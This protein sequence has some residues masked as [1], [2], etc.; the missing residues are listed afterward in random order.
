MEEHGIKNVEIIRRGIWSN[1]TQIQ[2]ENRADI[3]SGFLRD[4]YRPGLTVKTF[5]IPD[6]CSE[7]GIAHPNLVKMDI[8]GAEIEAVE[9]CL[10]FLKGKDIRFAIASY[11]IRNGCPTSNR[12]EALFRTAGYDARSGYPPHR[13]TWAQMK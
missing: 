9:G 13:T 3:G 8:E 6:A 5:S 12:L 11:H 7:L 10:S 4:P 2:F 1:T